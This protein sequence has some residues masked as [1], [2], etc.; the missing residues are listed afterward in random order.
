MRTRAPHEHA[1]DPGLVGLIFA[2]AAA[3]CGVRRCAWCGAWLG[4][5]LELPE[6]AV[7]HGICARC[8]AQFAPAPEVEELKPEVCH[9]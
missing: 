9:G 4:L 7:T 2:A 1:A 5:A 3:G 6:G 8:E